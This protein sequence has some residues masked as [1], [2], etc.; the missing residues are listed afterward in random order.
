MLRPGAKVSRKPRSAVIAARNNGGLPSTPPGGPQLSNTN[1]ALITPPASTSRHPQASRLA[2]LSPSPGGVQG[3]LPVDDPVSDSDD[4]VTDDDHPPPPPA[5]KGK[6][7][8]NIHRVRC[9]YCDRLDVVWDSSSGGSHSS[10]SDC[11]S[12]LDHDANSI[13]EDLLEKIDSLMD[14]IDNPALHSTITDDAV[15]NFQA[16]ALVALATLS[17]HGLSDRYFDNDSSGI[18]RHQYICL[19]RKI[20]GRYY[21]SVATTE[22]D[23]GTPGPLDP[24]GPAALNLGPIADLGASLRPDVGIPFEEEGLAPI[25]ITRTQARRQRRARARLTHAT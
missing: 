23:R 25:P 9:L 13:M 20:L 22:D 11:G 6:R 5:R 17:E 3:S 7:K 19:L 18:L 2:S 24:R 16:V 14:W 8:I 4:W 10:V 1:T 12:S 15:G 21:P